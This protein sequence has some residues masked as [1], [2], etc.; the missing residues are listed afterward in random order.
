MNKIAGY[1]SAQSKDKSRRYVDLY[2]LEPATG[3]GAGEVA[4]KIPADETVLAGLSGQK[5]PLMA[6]LETR[7]STVRTEYGERPTVTVTGVRV[8]RPAAANG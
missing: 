4:V 7:M 5:F 2:V 1:T 8:P 3:D 6:E